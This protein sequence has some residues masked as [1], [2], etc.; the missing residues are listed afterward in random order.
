MGWLIGILCFVT[1]VWAGVSISTWAYNA[2]EWKLMKWCDSSLGYRP[3]SG[4][5]KVKDNDKLIMALSIDKKD[6]DISG[7]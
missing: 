2:Q 5:Y 7:G 1:G 4:T 3:I 6:L